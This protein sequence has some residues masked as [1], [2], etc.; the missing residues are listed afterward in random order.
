MLNVKCYK[1]ISLLITHYSLFVTY[2]SLLITHCSLLITQYSI[3]NTQYS[4]KYVTAFFR[5]P[6]LPAFSIISSVPAYDPVL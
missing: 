5:T 3:L 4:F 1:L 2:Y 6:Y